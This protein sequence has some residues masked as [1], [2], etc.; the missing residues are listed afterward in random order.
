MQKHIGRKKKQ[1]GGRA[2]VVIVQC[3]YAGGK[4]R[5]ALDFEARIYDN[6]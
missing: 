6:K 1:Q 2:C 4:L 5:A 3:V